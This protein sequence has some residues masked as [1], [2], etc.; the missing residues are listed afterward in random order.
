LVYSFFNLGARW[1]CWP[2]YS[3]ERHEVHQGRSGRVRKDTRYTRAG[4]DGCGQTRGTPGPVWTGA[5]RQEVHQGRSGRVRKDTRYTRAGLDGCGKNFR[6]II[7]IISIKGWAIWPVPSPELQL[8]SPT[9]LRST[10]CSLSL[11]IVVV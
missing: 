9:F 3:R 7:I 6:V 11:W 10:D 5:E 8:L 1:G 4:L 2:L